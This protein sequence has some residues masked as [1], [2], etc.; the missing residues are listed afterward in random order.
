MKTKNKISLTIIY[1]VAI[2][3][4]C[5]KQPYYDIPTDA[6]GNVGITGVSSTT[7]SGITT[8]DDKFTVNATLPN[9]KA[10]DI[11]IAELLKL[12]VPS[13]G[14]AAQLLP[15]AGTQKNVTVGNDLKTTVTYTRAEAKLASVGDYVTVTLSG[16]TSQALL[17]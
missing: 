8:L 7:S 13:T 6:N 15:L 14:G 10:G 17:K 5:T 2:L 12:Q 4:G 3:S 1:V 16:K 11:M 9:A